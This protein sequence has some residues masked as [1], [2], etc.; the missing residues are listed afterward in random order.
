MDLKIA[1]TLF[2]DSSFIIKFHD[3]SDDEDD[4]GDGGRR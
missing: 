3:D 4:D 2:V 1:R